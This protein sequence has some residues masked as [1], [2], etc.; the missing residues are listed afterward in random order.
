[1]AVSPVVGMCR[2]QPRAELT[3]AWA[4]ASVRFATEAPIRQMGQE[5]R[6]LESGEGA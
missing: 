3:Q 1:M 4:E 5:L 2:R 6:G